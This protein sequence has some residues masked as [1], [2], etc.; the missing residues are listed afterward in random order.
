MS[1]ESTGAGSTVNCTPSLE[2]ARPID[3]EMPSPTPLQSFVGLLQWLAP[4]KAS[5]SVSVVST[6]GNHTETSQKAQLLLPM[7][8]LPP[9]SRLKGDSPSA[10]LPAQI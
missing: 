9:L 10:L 7:T 5:C 8:G 1:P 4:K 2:R 3:M 6:D